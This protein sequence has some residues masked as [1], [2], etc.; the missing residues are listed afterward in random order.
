[1]RVIIEQVSAGAGGIWTASID[2][3]RLMRLASPVRQGGGLS[4]L[5]VTRPF[6]DEV[7]H[8]LQ[9]DLDS[10]VLL[11]LGNTFEAVLIDS[12]DKD[13]QQPAPEL[14]KR[15]ISE[16]DLSFLEELKRLPD[17]LQAI[18][19][20]LLTEVR[21]VYPGKLVFSQRS[22]KFIESPD[23]FWVIRIQPRDKSFRVIVYGSPLEHGSKETIEL[24]DDMASY[25]NFK[26]DS[27][28][29][30]TEAVDVI[31]QSK[32]L[33]DRRKLLGK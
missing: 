4:V 29:Q 33:K 17:S 20:Q 28:Q 8:S 11:N 21:N 31:L 23:N 10:A 32:R 12:R 24:K 5:F 18:G 30:L 25:S 16:G 3:Q 13:I 2:P 1:M 22:G 19:K 9:F 6:F 26:I 7:T 14:Y 15:E 27:Q